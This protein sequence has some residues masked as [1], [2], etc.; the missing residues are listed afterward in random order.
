MPTCSG[1]HSSVAELV[2]IG[3]NRFTLGEIIGA[4]WLTLPDPGHRLRATGLHSSALAHGG[5]G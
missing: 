3:L 4:A 5:W 1:L 2:L